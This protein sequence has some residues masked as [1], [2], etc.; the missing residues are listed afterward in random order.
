[1][2]PTA[3][4]IENTQRVAHDLNNELALMFGYIEL[5]ALQPR[6]DEEPIDEMRNALQRARDLV[7]Q[8]QK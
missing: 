1:M 7:G 3:P 4:R 8:L 5:L 6:N 2:S